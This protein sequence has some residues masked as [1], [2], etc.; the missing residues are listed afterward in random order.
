MISWKI[1]TGCAAF[2]ILIKS[3][4]LIMKSGRFT[5]TLIIAPTDSLTTIISL[6]EK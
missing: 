5:F 4:L 1:T 6:N 3:E 2:N